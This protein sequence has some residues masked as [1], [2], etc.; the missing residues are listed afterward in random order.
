MGI[1]DDVGPEVKN[2]KKGDRVVACF[3]IGCGQCAP[4]PGSQGGLCTVGPLRL[5]PLPRL[6]LLLQLVPDV[7]KTLKTGI[8]SFWPCWSP[9][10]GKFMPCRQLQ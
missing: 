2:V 6:Q 1:V 9:V 8:T 5:H 10:A 7:L 4:C 3:D